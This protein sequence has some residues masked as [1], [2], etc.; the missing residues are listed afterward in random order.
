MRHLLLALLIA[1]LPLRAWVGD[2][3]AIAMQA[4][5]AGHGSMTMA[6]MDSHPGAHHGTDASSAT[7]DHQHPTCDVC[8]GP[9]MALTVQ[10]EWLPRATHN[11]VATPTER[12]ASSVPQPGIKPPIS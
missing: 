3:M 7:G 9:A 11:M 12:F 1:L 6:A 2:A 5:S 4:P 10:V 8:N